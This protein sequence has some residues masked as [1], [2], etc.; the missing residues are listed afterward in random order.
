MNNDTELEAW[1]YMKLCMSQHDAN[2]N[3]ILD[4]PIKK[5]KTKCPID[6][7]VVSSPFFRSIVYHIDNHI[8][9][10]Q[11]ILEY[12]KRDLEEYDH[13]VQD[14]Q[15]EQDDK[16][17]Q[18]LAREVVYWV[19]MIELYKTIKENKAQWFKQGKFPWSGVK[20]STP[21]FDAPPVRMSANSMCHVSKDTDLTPVDATSEFIQMEL[22]PVSKNGNNGKARRESGKGK[23]SSR[24]KRSRV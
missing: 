6:R 17:R 21:Y 15:V 1:S 19:K 5:K 13:Y 11:N 20:V 22:T 16:Y 23:R 4:K 14:E 2:G 9:T 24:S 18:E 12:R 3:F 8:E 10:A 7:K